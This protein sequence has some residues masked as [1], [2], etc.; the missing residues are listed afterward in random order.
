MPAISIFSAI[1]GPLNYLT[2]KTLSFTKRTGHNIKTKFC[3][4]ISKTETFKSLAGFLRYDI[5][6][7]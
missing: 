2:L 3:D 4:R 6:A 5:L 1:R 7:A